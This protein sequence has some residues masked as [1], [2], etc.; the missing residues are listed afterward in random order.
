MDEAKEAEKGNRII[1]HFRELDVYK[2]TFQCAMEIFQLTKTFPP[3]EKYSLTDQIR[4]S[5]RSVCSNIAEAW[6]KRRYKAA[7]RN[8]LTDAMQ[9]A[10]E[11]QTWL[12]FC[13]AC[14]YIDQVTFDKLDSLYERII[15]MLNSMEMKSDKFCF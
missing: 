10:S 8:K 6:K 15:S 1:K 5:S 7:F 9:E 3:E 4:P 2:L 13:I 11:T 12:D 14:E